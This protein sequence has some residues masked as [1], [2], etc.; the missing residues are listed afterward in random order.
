MR[1]VRQ[2]IRV[3]VL[4][5]SFCILVPYVFAQTDQA[6]TDA[7][8]RDA[9]KVFIDCEVW[10]PVFIQEAIGFI[11]RVEDSKEADIWLIITSQETEAGIMDYTISFR[12]QN[13]FEGDSSFQGFLDFEA[14]K[15]R[16]VE[17]TRLRLPL[18]YPIG[19]TAGTISSVPILSA[20]PNVSR[21]NVPPSQQVPKPMSVAISTAHSK[22]YPKSSS[23]QSLFRTAPAT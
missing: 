2:I 17:S 9:P 18:A 20:C 12:G 4:L 8:K 3:A 21:L 15:K 10:D 14:A 7:N 1:K 5:Y 19:L 16:I 22:T 11:T 13:E 6:D 23:A